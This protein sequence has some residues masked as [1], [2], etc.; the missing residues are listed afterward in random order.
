MP[1]SVSPSNQGRLQI[2]KRGVR[3]LTAP[4]MAHQ[5]IPS[6]SLMRSTFASSKQLS[7]SHGNKSAIP[8]NSRRKWCL[9]YGISIQQD[10]QRVGRVM[11]AK[12]IKTVPV[13]RDLYAINLQTQWRYKSYQPILCLFQFV[14]N[15]NI[16]HDDQYDDRA[17]YDVLIR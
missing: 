10:T 13:P 11:K 2:T 12:F 5:D 3:L 1:V 4:L 14:M 6:V 7:H 15:N 8:C 17:K 9:Y 16:H